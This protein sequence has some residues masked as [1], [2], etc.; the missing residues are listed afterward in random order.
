MKRT[1]LAAVMGGVITLMG[2]A[3]AAQAAPVSVPKPAEASTTLAQNAGYY[4]SRRHYHRRTWRHRPVVRYHRYRA[5]RRYGRPHYRYVRPYHH[6]HW[7]HRYYR[8]HYY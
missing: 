5:P 8:R 6:R 3:F 7:T 4:G 2:G 1:L